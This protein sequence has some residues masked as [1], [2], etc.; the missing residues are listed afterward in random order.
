MLRLVQSALPSTA[1]LVLSLLV[2][3]TGRYHVGAGHEPQAA[4]M[5]L[6][7][8]RSARARPSKAQWTL[9][10]RDVSSQDCELLHSAARVSAARGEDLSSC[11]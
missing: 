8:L 1:V 3:V 6:R 9:E 11:S 10:V 5:I 7:I 2:N 4:S